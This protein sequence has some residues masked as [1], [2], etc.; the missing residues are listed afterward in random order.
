MAGRVRKLI[1]EL[2]E[3]RT[4]GSDS[5]TPFLR[6]HLMM[7]GINPDAY[8]ESSPDD[9]AKVAALEAMIADFREQMA[10]F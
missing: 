6:A 5:V 4:R 8:T 3:L 7:R 2:I 1:D 9:P 10:R